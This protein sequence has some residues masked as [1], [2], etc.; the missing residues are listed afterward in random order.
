MHRALLKPM[1]YGLDNLKY[2]ILTTTTTAKA[3]WKVTEEV[4]RFSDV[5]EP[6]GNDTLQ[7][8]YNARS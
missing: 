7:K 4:V 2:L 3:R 8:L 1:F 6:V 5:V